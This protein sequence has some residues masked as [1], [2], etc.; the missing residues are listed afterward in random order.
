[1]NIRY[2]LMFWEFNKGAWA[3]AMIKE[4]DTTG[5]EFVAGIMEVNPNTVRLWCKMKSGYEHFPYP[6]HTNF[7]RFCNEFDYD[8]RDFYILGE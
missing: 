3:Q 1:M 5:I 7:I 2:K 8:P 4:V 6:N